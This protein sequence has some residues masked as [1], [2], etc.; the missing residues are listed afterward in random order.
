M[1]TGPAPYSVVVIQEGSPFPPYE[2]FDQDGNLHASSERR[3]RS[4]FFFYPKDNT[5]GCTAEAC[6]FRDHLS[7]FAAADLGVQVYGVSPDSVKSHKKFAEKY[8]LNFPLLAD[9]ER[10]LIEPL[11]L[12]VE[13]TLYGRKYMG[14]DRTTILV[15]ADGKIEKVW[16]KLKPENHAVEV[17]E[18]LRST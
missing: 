13:K 18:Y 10:T 3:G 9:P 14:V 16:R 5:S 6:S 4:L 1:T 7:D 11:G 15:D 8:Q 2:L 17:L 12:W